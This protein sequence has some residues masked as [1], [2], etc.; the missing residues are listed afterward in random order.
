MLPLNPTLQGSN[1]TSKPIGYN[2]EPF[3]SIRRI[4]L[5]QLDIFFT[6]FLLVLGLTGV[7]S[8]ST[9][10]SIVTKDIEYTDAIKSRYSL[11]NADVRSRGDLDKKYL[12]RK[13][14]AIREDLV[15]LIHGYDGNL[16]TWANFPGLLASDEHDERDFTAP[17]DIY[18][19][20]YHSGPGAATNFEREA[21][22]LLADL[23]AIINDWSQYK[24]LWIVTHSQGGIIFQRALTSLI[25]QKDDRLLLDRIGGAILIAS[26][27]EDLRLYNSI[28]RAIGSIDAEPRALL[29]N[30]PQRQG[31]AKDWEFVRKQHPDEFNRYFIHNMRFLLGRDDEVVEDANLKDRFTQGQ[32]LT[33]DSTHTSIVKIYETGHPTFSQIKRFFENWNPS[34]HMP[35]TTAPKVQPVTIAPEVPAEKSIPIKSLPQRFQSFVTKIKE[36]TKLSE[37]NNRV[38]LY[39]VRAEEV[40]ER[41]IRRL[42]QYLNHLKMAFE[43][44]GFQY[45]RLL[46]DS[47]K[48]LEGDIQKLKDSVGE[49][50]NSLATALIRQDTAESARLNRV[51]LE[52]YEAIERRTDQLI[53]DSLPLTD[54]SLKET[55]FALSTDASRLGDIV[56]TIWL[57]VK[58]LSE[59][60][61]W[62]DRVDILETEPQYSR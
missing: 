4:E 24:R 34:K 61:E 29:D 15:V 16:N 28:I 6:L 3:I 57:R 2:S 12:I 59:T 26:P 7:T 18:I 33:V 41:G 43:S 1:R 52:T 8:C 30:S 39:R 46:S 42:R 56:M 53:T 10:P 45:R 13:K 25:S 23:T 19:Y 51:L 17:Y 14:G 55:N 5:N 54:S 44:E 22:P 32:F 48:R 31:L 27:N 35:R 21:R 38:A 40:D 9:N 58:P 36:Q 37:A 47:G 20:Q 60:R 50:E 49:M 11:K 62:S